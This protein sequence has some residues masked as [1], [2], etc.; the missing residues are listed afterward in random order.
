VTGAFASEPS[1][2]PEEAAAIAAVLAAAEAGATAEVSR[3]PIPAWRR[4]AL[5]EG[6]AGNAGVRGARS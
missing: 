4:A 5:R 3:S 6:V 2:T 1:A